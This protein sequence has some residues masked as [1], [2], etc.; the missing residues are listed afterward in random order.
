MQRKSAGQRQLS[1]TPSSV[2]RRPAA[3]PAGPRRPPRRQRGQAGRG[4]VQHHLRDPRAGVVERHR[5]LDVRAR[6]G[7]RPDLPADHR[8]GGQRHPLEVMASP[9][10]RQ[11]SMSRARGEL[12]GLRD[13]PLRG[14]QAARPITVGIRKLR[15]EAGPAI[16][17]ARRMG[18]DGRAGGRVVEQPRARKT[19]ARAT[20]WSST[21]VGRPAA[22]CRRGI[23]WSL[24]PAQYSRYPQRVR[25]VRR[26]PLLLGARGVEQ[27][28][29][30]KRPSQTL[31]AAR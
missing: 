12:R 27:P 4:G 28:A 9:D 10:A 13:P 30:P 25:R 20:Y 15:A 1:S 14:A 21:P 5:L 18:G 3:R 7:V 16:S 23:A 31:V 19:S 24:S 17:M 2:R 22:R 6:L 29:E 11:I 8:R 26:P